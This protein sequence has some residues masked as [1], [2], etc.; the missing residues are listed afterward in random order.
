ME[1]K[2]KSFIDRWRDKYLWFNALMFILVGDNDI[3]FK[4]PEQIARSEKKTKIQNPIRKVGQPVKP[5][6]RSGM[7]IRRYY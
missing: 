6:S 4:T 3:I 1:T 7:S 5:R 2:N